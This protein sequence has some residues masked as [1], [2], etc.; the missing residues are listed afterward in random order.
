MVVARNSVQ[1]SCIIDRKGDILAWN[2]GTQEI[3][4][5]TLPPSDGY[6]TWDGGD[7]REV[8]FSCSAARTSTALLP[9]KPT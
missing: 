7:F 3:I 8:T 5:A 1:G 2:E 4:E 9:T 6:R